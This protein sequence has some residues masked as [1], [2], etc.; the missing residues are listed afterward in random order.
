MNSPVSLISS[1]HSTTKWWISKWVETNTKLFGSSLKS[2]AMDFITSYLSRG[3]TSYQAFY[4]K[5]TDTKSK[6][7]TLCSF[8]FSG[9]IGQLTTRFLKLDHLSLTFFVTSQLEM[10]RTLDGNLLTAFALGAFKT[11]YQ[12]LGGLCLKIKNK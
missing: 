6:Y 4:K 3:S 8:R 10:L 9:W 1:P 7:K 2:K 12:F 11:K 5:A